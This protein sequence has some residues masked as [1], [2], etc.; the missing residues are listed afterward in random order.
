MANAILPHNLVRRS[1]N[2]CLWPN[3]VTFSQVVLSMTVSQKQNPMAHWVKNISH[4]LLTENV[5][6][7]DSS[8]SVLSVTHGFLGPFKA[9]VLVEVFSQ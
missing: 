3:P 1:A 6:K 2:G 4:L 5:A 8:S 7:D 9:P